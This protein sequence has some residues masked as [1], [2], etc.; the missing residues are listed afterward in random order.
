MT[1]FPRSLPEFQRRFPDEAACVEYLAAER[2]PDGFRCPGCDGAK[3]WRLSTKPFTWEVRG[4]RP[5]DVGH[6]RDGD[7]RLQA[8]PHGM[9]L[10][11]LSDGDPL[12]RHLRDT[13]ANPARPRLLQNGVVA[14]R[15]APP[16]D[17]RP[18]TQPLDGS[19]RNRRGH[20]P[21]PDERRPRRRRRRTKPGGQDAGDRVRSKSSAT[22][23]GAFA[24]PPSTTIPQKASA[25]SSPP[26]S[27]AV[28][29][30]RPTDGPPIPALPR[31]ITIPM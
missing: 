12:Q 25:P 4:L 14:V 15:Q 26:A 6:R 1:D 22:A 9:V 17:G 29:R 5:A 20:D 13:T 21:V 19:G 24:S 18:R 10:G 7:A 16:G 30:S 28:R 8:R 11:R 3:A 31:S 27:L 23:R 2:W